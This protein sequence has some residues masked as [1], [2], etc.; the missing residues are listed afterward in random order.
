MWDM[1][2]GGSYSFRTEGDLIGH[3]LW[4]NKQNEES[5]TD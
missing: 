1:N 5:L 4:K 2:T 3:I